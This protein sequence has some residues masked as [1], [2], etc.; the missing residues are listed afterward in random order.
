MP[1][2]LSG[3]VFAVTCLGLTGLCLLVTAWMM[4]RTRPESRPGVLDPAQ[5]AKGMFG[6]AC[7][8]FLCTL[9]LAQRSL[10]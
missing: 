4:S 2:A 8:V 6:L 1:S 3:A 9:V 7:F 5:M 10:F